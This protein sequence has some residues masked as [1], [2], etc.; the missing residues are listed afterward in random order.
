M[1]FTKKC[2]QSV[3][4]VSVLEWMAHATYGAA[5]SAG[6]GRSQGSPLKTR[7]T[8]HTDPEGHQWTSELAVVP[9]SV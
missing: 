3:K 8:F 4:P 5:S 6:H 7:Y 2:K 1:G 9:V